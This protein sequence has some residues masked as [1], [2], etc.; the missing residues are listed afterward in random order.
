MKILGAH[1]RNAQ[2]MCSTCNVNVEANKSVTCHYYVKIEKME[3]VLGTLSVYL[4]LVQTHI[5]N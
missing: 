4:Y 1:C 2:E 5:L 3:G